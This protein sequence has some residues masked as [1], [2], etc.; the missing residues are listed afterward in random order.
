MRAA[1]ILKRDRSID[2]LLSNWPWASLALR[3]LIPPV[4]DS[5]A[6]SISSVSV[7]RQMHNAA[8]Y[9]TCL[10]HTFV[11]NLKKNK[12]TRLIY[13]DMSGYPAREYI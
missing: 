12:S 1:L 6:T 2:V 3:R 10:A 13:L 7:K 8:S 11:E 4:Y 9:T 5:A